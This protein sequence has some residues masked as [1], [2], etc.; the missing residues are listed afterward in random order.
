MSI[1]NGFLALNPL[2]NYAKPIQKFSLVCIPSP[3]LTDY[4]LH[5]YFHHYIFGY[6]NKKILPKN[7][8]KYRN[9]AKNSLKI[10]HYHE[11]HWFHY[12]FTNINLYNWV[13]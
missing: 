12:F 9:D 4:P 10:K 2:E 5:N 7:A 13:I 11:T 1:D 3:K 6:N 8:N